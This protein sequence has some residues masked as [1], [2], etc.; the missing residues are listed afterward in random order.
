MDG[1]EYYSVQSRDVP[2]GYLTVPVKVDDNGDEFDAEMVAGS[3]GTI[4]SSSG[5]ETE[6]GLAGL[7]TVEPLSGWWMYEKIGPNST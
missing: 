6:E 1:I 7:D 4:C 5:E 3:T 2:S